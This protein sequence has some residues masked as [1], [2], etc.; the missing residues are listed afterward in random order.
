[1]ETFAIRLMALAPVYVVIGLIMGVYGVPGAIVLAPI[2]LFAAAGA[3]L[4]TR[5]C[6]HCQSP[7]YAASKKLWLSSVAECP[8]CGRDP[9]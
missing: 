8:A 7:L 2:L 9:R 1:M 4:A 3:Y 5:K 6:R